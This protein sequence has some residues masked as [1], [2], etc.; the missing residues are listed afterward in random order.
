MSERRTHYE[1]LGVPRN[2]TGEDVRRRFRELARTEHPDKNQSPGAH[3][4]FLRINEAYLVLS[5]A[6]RRASYD[7]LL[8]DRDRRDSEQRRQRAASSGYRRQ[9]PPGSAGEPAS[10]VRSE[11]DLKERDQRRQEAARF[12]RMAQDAY[13]RGHI[14]EAERLCSEVLSRVRNGTAHEI[15]GDIYARQSRREQAIRHYTQAA[16]ILVNNGLVMSKLNRLIELERGRW[17]RESAPLDAA[18][19][20]RSVARLAHQ[21]GVSCFGGAA[22]VFLTVIWR[23]IESVPLGWP[24]TPNCTLAQLICAVLAGLIAG[25]VLSLGGWVHRFADVMKHS[26][27]AGRLR[28]TPLW[29]VLSAFSLISYYLSLVVY[30]VIAL[31]QEAFSGSLLLAYIAAFVLTAGFSLAAPL[32]AQSETLLW[33]GNL[34][35][36]CVLAG[37]YLTDE[38]SS[39]D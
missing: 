31:F 30:L 12:L 22:I 3:E 26:A 18:R 7:L 32:E 2:A 37:W 21:L 17:G 39:G 8:R 28:S 20:R 36:V 11:R 9:P 33:G 25:V 24:L 34:V 27:P 10:R 6:S 19:G 5:D 38:L 35:F 14:R 23:Q 13:A 4:R 1:V 29:T 16:Q 15:L